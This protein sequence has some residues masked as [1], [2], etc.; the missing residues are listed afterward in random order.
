VPLTNNTFA[1][2]GEVNSQGAEF[3]AAVR[4]ID[5]LRV[6]GNLAFVEATYK[7]F[8]SFTGN[9]PSNVAPQIINVGASYRWASSWHWPV[10]IGGSVRH[11]GRR[12]VFEDDLTTMEPYTTADLYAFVDI[13]GQAFGRPELKN[14]RVTF[15]IRNITDAIYAAY[16]DPGYQDQIYL[17][18][19]RTYEIATSFKW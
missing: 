1:L 18:A 4:P 16:S 8:G 11:V 10:E 6:W 14:T 13:P 9:T 15:R 19:P 5:G 7:N 3:S 12:F 2:A 17:G